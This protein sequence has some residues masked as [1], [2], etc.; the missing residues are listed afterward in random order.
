MKRIVNSVAPIRICD[1]GG[2]TDTWFAKY[3]KVLNIGVYPYVE[4]Q[5]VVTDA[6]S[7]E[8]EA[9]GIDA[10]VPG[11]AV[12]EIAGIVG[13]DTEAFRPEDDRMAA[14]VDEQAVELRPGPPHRQNEHCWIEIPGVAPVRI[15]PFIHPGSIS[16]LNPAIGPDERRLPHSALGK[17]QWRSQRL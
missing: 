8:G 7:G 10:G 12:L 11:K 13:G 5:M 6:A 14:E 9:Y 4:C 15:P 1:L 16:R 2:W 3:G 17:P